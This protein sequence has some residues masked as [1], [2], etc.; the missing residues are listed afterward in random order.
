MQAGGRLMN[1]ELLI[2]LAVFLYV[3]LWFLSN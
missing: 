2:P 1:L 3:V